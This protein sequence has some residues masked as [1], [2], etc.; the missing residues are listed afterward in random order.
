M[1]WF[2][3]TPTLNVALDHGRFTGPKNNASHMRMIHMCYLQ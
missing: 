1:T 2:A 3:P